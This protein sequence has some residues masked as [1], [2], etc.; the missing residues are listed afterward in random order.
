MSFIS[1]RQWAFRETVR[2]IFHNGGLFFFATLLSALALSIPLFITCVAYGLSEPL[3]TLPTSVEITVFATTDVNLGALE[4]SIAAVDRVAK[5]D[6]VQKDAALQALN[7]SL[8][9]RQQKNVRN[10]L[11]DIVIASLP[12]KLAG[13]KSSVL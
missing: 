2:G 1:S 6:I 3:R 5:T 10:P 9:V 7:E 8:G 11:P 12:M 13:M 4:K